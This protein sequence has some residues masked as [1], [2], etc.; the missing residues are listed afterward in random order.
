MRG[1]KASISEC[2]PLAKE[3]AAA[4]MCSSICPLQGMRVR[5]RRTK[6]Q[7]YSH[8]HMDRLW[9]GA[10]Q[11]GMTALD[12]T[13]DTAAT[14]PHVAFVPI[15]DLPDSIRVFAVYPTNE[16]ARHFE[17]MRQPSEGSVVVLYR[18]CLIRKT[19]LELERR[20]CQSC[21]E[22]RRKLMRSMSSRY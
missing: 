8:S 17:P 3:R 13:A 18:P 19:Q 2:V 21:S 5:R 20:S 15:A 16:S 7:S 4:T 6:Y 10:G 22:V 9:N 1:M 14:S 12:P 11:V